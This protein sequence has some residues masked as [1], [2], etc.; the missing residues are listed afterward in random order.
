ML[1]HL[2][3]IEQ[4]ACAIRFARATAEDYG[5]NPNRI[6]LIGNS[7]GASTG[8]VVALAGDDFEGDCV[9]NDASALPDALVAFEGPYDYTMMAYSPVIDHTF[10]KEEDLE[11]WEA[12]NPYSHIGRN[13][14]LQVRLLHGEDEDVHWY[15][16]PPQASI[17]FYQALENAGYDVTLTV[18][19]STSHTALGNRDSEVFQIAIQQ[20]LEVAHSPSP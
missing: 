19:D 2:I 15:D 9:E 8:A 16:I 13:P 4:I 1:P 18:V 5:G 17:D 7:A 11:L 6:T 3:A 10:L 12:I 20:A 14:D